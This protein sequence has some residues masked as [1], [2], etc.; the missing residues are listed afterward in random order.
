MFN[1]HFFNFLLGFIGMILLGLIGLFVINLIFGDAEEA[2][3]ASPSALIDVAHDL[4]GD[5]KF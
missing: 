5:A 4:F 3:K 2:Q 1:R